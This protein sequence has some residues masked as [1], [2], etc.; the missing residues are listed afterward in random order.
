[1]NI[2]ILFIP[3]LMFL[4]L[5]SSCSLNRVLINAAGGFMES[6][7][8]VVYAEDDL[9][10]AEQ[11]MANNLKMIELLLSRDP[12]N[13]SLNLIAAQGFGAF[14]MAFVE[15]ENPLRAARLYQRGVDYA[16]KSLPKKLRFEP[17]IKPQYLEILLKEYTVND[18][19]ALFWLGYNWGSH[20]LQNLDNPR[21]LV[22]LSRVEMIMNRVLELDEKYNFAGVHLFYGSFY[23][24]RPPL[25]GGNPEK[26]RQHFE[27]NLELTNNSFYMTKF[28]M[29]RYYA[30]QVQDRILFDTLTQEITNMD[31]DQ[32]PDIRLMNAIA[33]KKTKI[34]IDKQDQYW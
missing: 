7:I 11:F 8:E 29:A 32:Y 4:I 24:A 23:S 21:M 1:M 28:L 9:E 14:A 10:I 33:K 18:V 13:Q 26:G 15:D 25:L 31:I 12:D 30:I 27:R 20:V 2:K 5:A 22:N 19:P 3:F 17:S 6:G 34:L 16:F